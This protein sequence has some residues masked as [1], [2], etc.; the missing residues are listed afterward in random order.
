[1]LVINKAKKLPDSKE[2]I[3]GLEETLGHLESFG[4]SNYQLNLGIARGLDYY[5]GTVF[6]IYAKGLGAQN[7]ICGGGN[8]SLTEAFG[9]QKTATSGF[10]FGFDRVM[11]AI[12]AQ[13]TTGQEDSFVEY[14]VVP[15]SSEHLNKAIRIS[16]SLRKKSKCEVDIM[17]RKL[18]KA[19]S[20]ADAKN[21]P[22]V[23]IVGEEEIL[24]K[25]MKTGKQ[26]SIKIKDLE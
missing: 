23:I 3:K 12:E 11:L 18:G 20:Y 9:G 16:A 10:A 7:Q 5:T 26:E 15:T 14:F 8:Y 2:K 22:F 13:G 19:L 4:V 6:E 24:K 1:M 25:D 21:I 17:R